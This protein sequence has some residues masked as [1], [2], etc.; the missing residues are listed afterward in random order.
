MRELR[1]D[2]LRW[3]IGGFCAVIGALMLV[4][5]HQFGSPAYATLRPLLPWWGA[6][7][8]LGGTGLL[9]VAALDLGRLLAVVAHVFVGAALL[10]LGNCSACHSGSVEG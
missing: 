2:T 3:A 5:P 6:A 4:A 7:F 9:L 8:L 1:I 10:L